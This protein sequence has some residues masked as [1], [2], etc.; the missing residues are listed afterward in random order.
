MTSAVAATFP[1][2]LQTYALLQIAAEAYLGTTDRNDPAAPTST[3][4]I[5]LTAAMLTKGNTH[6]SK[7]TA[8]Q[9]EQF[10][11]EWKVLSHQPNTA[12]GF[13]ATLFVYIGEPDSARGVFPGQMVVSFRSTEFIDDQA[14]DSKATNELE[15][16]EGGWAFGQIADMQKW[17]SS[18]ASQVGSA[19]VDVTGY[20]LGGHLATAFYEL[21]SSQINKVYTFNGA[22]VG[23]LD[24]GVSLESL[25]AGFEQH[26]TKGANADYFTNADALALYQALSV[27]Y[28]ENKPLTTAG[29][30]ADLNNVSAVL[31]MFGTERGDSVIVRQLKLLAS[32]LDRIAQVSSQIDDM[33]SIRPSVG[34]APAQ[35]T[36]TSNV[37]AL[38]LDY[39]LA[40]LRAM[41]RSSSYRS[42]LIAGLFTAY[43]GKSLKSGV[44]RD[45]FFDIVGNAGPSAVANS[46]YHYG[47]ETGVF[48]EEQPL[49]RGSAVSEA[50][51]ATYRATF[52]TR[53]LLNQY[54]LNDFGDE[55]SIVLIED[56]LRVQS[57]LARLTPSIGAD[58]AS[59]G[60]FAPLFRA[61]TKAAGSKGSANSGQGT[62]EGDA[63]ENL[64]DSARRVL[65]GPNINPT[66][67]DA[68]RIE[69]LKGNTWY[70]AAPKDPALRDALETSVN[71][72]VAATESLKNQLRFNLPSASMDGRRDFASFLSLYTLSTVRIS[73]AS[74][75]GQVKLD[76]FLQGKWAGLYQQWQTDQS[77]PNEKRT[78]TDAWL[79]AR[80][81]LLAALTQ[82]NLRNEDDVSM[83][84][85]RSSAGTLVDLT[86]NRTV[87]LQGGNGIEVRFGT[88]QGELLQVTQGGRG[89]FFGG[90]G[91]DSLIGAQ[92]ADYLE[93]GGGNDELNGQG[94]SDVLLGG[95]GNDTLDG[96][97]NAADRLIGG[98]GFDTYIFQGSWGSDT[99][100]D[101]DGDG[102]LSVEGFGAGLPDG[103]L[104][105]GTS[106][107]YWSADRS[108]RYLL[109]KGSNGTNTLFISIVGK[110]G[111]IRIEDW[112]PAKNLGITLTDSA[113]PPP[114][115]RHAVGDVQKLVDEQGKLV[116][117]GEFGYAT[118]AVVSA[119]DIQNGNA[120]A[121]ELSGGLDNDGLAGQ[122]GDDL[123]N[124]GAGDDLLIGG[125]GSDVL[126]G[127]SGND[128]IIGGKPASRSMPTTRATT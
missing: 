78:F 102:R 53:L 107:V 73:G 123:L 88:A 11:L 100:L 126:Q 71:A 94:G 63:V 112:S 33:A 95:D 45:S 34:D 119:Q 61:A 36:G 5:D 68:Q 19:Q 120:A 74:P 14:R 83:P 125:L 118:G 27:K 40:A 109:E 122:D 48:I 43:F 55:H 85:G 47:I 37:E 97:D 24:S 113:T 84:V 86:S 26:R 3:G 15:I 52:E 10:S 35:I 30:R 6:S 99:V 75:E 76:V 60:T 56:S 121:D 57:A 77:L 59:V 69:A 67:T 21:H 128:V 80:G 124:G 7:M 1:Q 42:N 51:L 82:A 81:D 90:D 115:T 106:N 70:L 79:A 17:W 2:V 108:V 87:R 117:G 111:S 91:N 28:S 105:Y 114:T 66:L 31:T 13:S 12:T 89:K 8:Q 103:K 58:A 62:A 50:A 49:W 16:K 54:D 101:A 127:G 4:P 23:K 32:A 93:G 41:N 64:L 98:S 96:G 92:I 25:I 65:L 46:Q 110:S 72:F 9:A 29:V 38:R 18:V 104:E 22:G 116:T 39:Q 20:S 44:A